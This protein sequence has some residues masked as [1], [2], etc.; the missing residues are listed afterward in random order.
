MSAPEPAEDIMEFNAYLERSDAFI[1]KV[2]NHVA[3]QMTLLAPSDIEQ[4]ITTAL[5]TRALHFFEAAQQLLP[6]YPEP[7][8]GLCRV[9]FEASQEIAYHI[10]AR[11]G[12]LPLDSQEMYRK[13]EG[14]AA[15]Y[16]PLSV[17][18]LRPKEIRLAL[19]NDPVYHSLYDHLSQI[20]GDLSIPL[21]G[22]G[23]FNFYISG[24][25][26]PIH[27]RVRK[28]GI[29]A[30]IRLI[31]SAYWLVSASDLVYAADVK[32]QSSSDEF[33]QEA[34]ALLQLGNKISKAF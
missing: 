25:Y 12:G 23:Y 13:W 10:R 3:Q 20:Y 32:K 1:T 8:M 9:V 22:S 28:M 16:D 14:I 21:H 29:A 24:N 30:R 6:D 18:E 11:S 33:H 34:T 31:W 2:K 4:G 7:C 26:P 19:Y 17:Q 5:L 27:A 15:N